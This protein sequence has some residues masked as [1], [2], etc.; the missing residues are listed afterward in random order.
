MKYAA[1]AYVKPV[2]LRYLFFLKKRF[3]HAPKPPLELTTY[4]WGNAPKETNKQIPKIIWL[5]W[6]QGNMPVICR[7]CVKRIKRLNPDFEINV[8]NSESVISFLPELEHLGIK[9]ENLSLAV[10]ADLIRLMLLDKFGG[11]WMDI[12]IILNSQLTDLRELAT[13]NQVEL[14]LF[15][16]PANGYISSSIQNIKYPVTENWFLAAVKGS[17]FIAD[18]RDEFLRCLTSP[19]P[20]DYYKADKNYSSYIEYLPPSLLDYL[21]VYISGQVLM[22]EMK[23]EYRI[24]FMNA[25]ETGFLYPKSCYWNNELTVKLLTDIEKPNSLPVLIKLTNDTRRI[26]ELAIE[27]NDYIATSLMKELLD[28]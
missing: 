25:Y 21:L 22:H 11:F 6:H 15:T 19:V 8:L 10:Y 4:S 14:L 20:T 12:S 27:K 26:A 18:W 16:K 28:E 5:Y 13:D 1:L 7:Q 3:L 24:L 9:Y 17:K 2:L 23:Q